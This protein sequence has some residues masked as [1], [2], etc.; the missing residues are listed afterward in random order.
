MTPKPAPHEYATMQDFTEHNTSQAPYVVPALQSKL[1]TIINNRYELVQ[2]LGH[3]GMGTVFKAKHLAV[4]RFFAL[5][6]LPAKL[7]QQEQFMLRLDRE[8]KTAGQLNHPNLVSV[9]D[10]G[11][12]ESGEAFIVMDFVAGNT[13]ATRLAGQHRLPVQQALDFFIQICEGLTHAHNLGIIHRDLK[14]A[15][16]MIT[17]DTAGFEHLKVVDFGIAR[18]P[19]H[20]QGQTLTKTGDIFGSPLYMSPEQCKGERV[21]ARSDIYSLGCVMYESLSGHPPLMGQSSLE[22]MMLHKEGAPPRFDPALNI[23][24]DLQTIVLRALEKNPDDRFQNTMQLKHALEMLPTRRT[25]NTSR[26]ISTP[27]ANNSRQRLTVLICVVILSGIAAVSGLL[28]AA[29]NEK[30]G[31]A[32][33]KT[34]Q[35]VERQSTSGS[36]ISTAS[37]TAGTPMQTLTAPTPTAETQPAP[38]SLALVDKAAKLVEKYRKDKTAN[39]KL[40]EKESQEG[41]SYI[42]AALKLSPNM[43]GAYEQRASFDVEMENIDQGIE[44]CKKLVQ[45]CPSVP[46][47]HSDYSYFL[48]KAHRKPDAIDEISKAIAIAK[49]PD[50]LNTRGYYYHDLQDYEAAIKDLQPVASPKLMNSMQI[51]ADSY[52][53]LRKPEQAIKTM[54]E[55]ID[56]AGEIKDKE[57]IAYSYVLRSRAEGDLKRYEKAILD[58]KKAMQLSK[59]MSWLKGEA[60]SLEEAQRSQTSKQQRSQFKLIREQ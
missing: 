53:H 59:T 13:L 48:N 33:S 21:D 40:A 1:G 41:L 7:S 22:T 44:D 39:P 18:A 27:V 4:N 25:S 28:F 51:L 56:Q 50:L 3:G 49:T 35:T 36:V 26:E 11:I 16:I 9:Y 42:D 31:F 5:K 23:P 43:A 15:N 19:V 55:F 54:N 60:N 10:S 30:T 6:L 14:P 20:V 46:V 24:A 32:I 37:G 38:E 58:I 8:A 52:I 12:S 17:C 47:Y 2:E 57:T 34:Q 29:V 45:L